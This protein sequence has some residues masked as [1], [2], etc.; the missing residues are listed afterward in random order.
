MPAHL[1]DAVFW[2]TQD[3]YLYVR[4]TSDN[5]IIVGG[6]DEPFKDAKK[7]DL[8]IEEK[9]MELKTLLSELMPTVAFT[10]DFCWAGTYGVTKDGLPYIGPHPDFPRSYFILGF[11][12]NGITFS[13]MGMKIISD[14][15]AGKSNKFLEY[16]KF[17]R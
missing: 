9:G 6:A 3:P 4:S 13:I 10:P 16:F 14:A 12:G 8:I 1:N 7:R 11:G 17:E 5:R 15:L 2:D